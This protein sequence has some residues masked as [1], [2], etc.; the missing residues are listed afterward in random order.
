MPALHLM[1]NFGDAFQVYEPDQPVPFA[2]CTESWTVGLWSTYHIVDWPANVKFFGVHFKAGG[3]YPFLRHPLSELH[4]R[5]VSMDAIWGHFAAEIRERLYNA[6]TIQAGFAIFERLLLARLC[7]VPHGLDVVQY[8]IAEITRH[9]GTLSIQALSDRIGISQSHLGTLF[10]RLVG[11]PPKEM[12]RLHRF[13]YIHRLIDPTRTIDWARVAHQAG[14]YD[15]SHFNRD[16]IAFLGQSPSEYLRL[17]RQQY[18]DDPEHNHI[19]RPLPT[20]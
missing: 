5:V 16:F 17:R 4:N 10:K 8:A 2:T 20:D 12:A 11:I 9:Q 18:T 1:V 13:G 15:Q 7:E 14:Y 19:L 6:P 3:V